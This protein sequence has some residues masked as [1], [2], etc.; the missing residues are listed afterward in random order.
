MKTNINTGLT[1]AD[2]IRI[3]KSEDANDMFRNSLNMAHVESREDRVI[4]E[5]TSA[6]VGKQLVVEIDDETGKIIDTRYIGIR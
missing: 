5:I 2:A 3:A 4:W 6:T 1:E